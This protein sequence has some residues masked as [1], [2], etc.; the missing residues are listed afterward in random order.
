MSDYGARLGWKFH[1]AGEQEPVRL[2]TFAVL[3]LP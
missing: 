1:S 2:E 3:D